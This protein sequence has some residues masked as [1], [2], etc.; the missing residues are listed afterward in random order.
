MKPITRRAQLE[1]KLRAIL[2]LSTTL[3]L[4]LSPSIYA[5]EGAI[6]KDL[7][8]DQFLKSWLVLKS[9]PVPHESGRA[10]DEPAQKNSFA[11]D[12]L[13]EVGGEA[14]I[15][16][17]PGMK[18]KI[19]D[20]EREWQLVDSK[21][22][23]VDLRK[24]ADPADFAIAYASAEL[25]MP[26]ASKGILGIGS[27]DA[28]KVWLNGKL[29]HENWVARG[30][31]TDDDCV[32]VEFQRGKNRILLKVQNIQQD[33]GFTCRLMS[34][35]TQAQKL[36]TASWGGAD[37]EVLKTLLDQGLDVNARGLVGLT[38]LQAARLH[39]ESEAVEYLKK[40]GADD[41]AEMPSID[42]RIDALF[43][44]LIKGNGAG[45]TVMAA[46][47][48][49]VL[50]QKA[51]GLA[52]IEKQRAVNVETKFRIGSIT[53]QF[54]A[55]AILKLQEEGKLSVQDKLSRYIPD[56]PRGNEVTLHYLLT[57]TS[58]IHSYTDKSGFIEGVTAPIKEEDLIKSFK[59]D[60]YDFDP[61]K[62][63]L[64]DNSGFFLLG[65]IVEKVSGESY[66]DYLRKTFFEPLGMTNTGVHRSD[67]VLQD[68]ALGYGFGQGEF[69]K[70]LNWDMSWAGGAGALYS[71]VGDLYRWNEA[72]FGG[73]VL[74][75][76][77]LKAAFTPVKTEEN[78]NQQS[79]DGYG[80]GWGISH[81]RGTEE[82]SHGGGLNG[83]TSYLLRIPKENFTVAVLV[84]AA[85]AAPGTDPDSLAHLV[86]EL[87]LGDKLAP[88]PVHSASTNIPTKALEAVVGRY[89]YG[90]AILT[91]TRE[92]NHLYAQLSGQPRFE[93]Y[94]KSETEFFWKVVDAQVTF[95]KDEAGVVTKAIHHQNGATF[96]APRIKD[97]IEAKVNPADFDAVVGKYDYGQGKAILTVTRDSDHVFAQLTGQPKFEIFPKSPTEFFWRAVNA[98]VTFVKDNSGRVVKAVHSQGGRTFDAPRI[99]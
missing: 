99:E 46:Q 39:G 64:Y 93:I 78:K 7:K 34:R 85:P 79:E 71:T 32:P 86:T 44:Q 16:P 60:P 54:T 94:P 52:D 9:I 67:V 63:W 18:I 24:G 53:K 22:D 90:S 50:F 4:G 96:T 20:R 27:D 81:F 48:G 49:T 83:F 70:A 19:G 84:N 17:K 73:K 45:A 12:W 82:I 26:E 29:I 36:V 25:D 92:R 66:E 59:N 33:W 1:L 40:R 30:C 47:N 14:K 61:G 42:E 57:H 74:K 31:Q 11:Q 43:G 89:D 75:E 8:P 98:Q 51:Y 13:A 38:P 41:K 37:L 6:Y 56:F 5:Q 2:L 21:M 3:A 80:Y 28:V 23:V 58:G 55:S 97:Q 15:E 76:S 87:C 10:P 62:R 69:T 77:S 91:V 88:R 95:V 35:K 65:Y 72:V 68:E